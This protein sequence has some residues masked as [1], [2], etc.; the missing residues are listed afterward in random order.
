MLKLISWIK[1]NQRLRLPALILI[2]SA[3]IHLINLGYPDSVVFDEVYFGK[4]ATSYCCSGKNF[5]TFHPPHGILLIAGAAKLF[6]YKGTVAFN[7]I[8]QT[9]GAESPVGLRLVPALSGTVLPLIL[10]VLLRQLGAS[11]AASLMGA[12]LVMFDNA[13]ILQSRVIALDALLL[14]AIFSSLACFIAATRASTKAHRWVLASGCLAGLA[15]GIKFT[16]LVAVGLPGVM[17]LMIVLRGFSQKKLTDW[18]VKWGTFFVGFITIYLAGWYLHFALLTQPG[19]G[20]AWMVASGN[21]FADTIHLHQKMLS[22]NIGL[23]ATHQDGSPWWTWPIMRT[24]VY[25]WGQGDSALYLIGNPVIWWGIAVLFVAVLIDIIDIGLTRITQ[26]RIDTANKQP[27]NYLWL[28]IFGYAIALFPLIWVPRVLFMYHYLTALLFSIMAAVLWLDY[29]GWT[30]TG[31]IL[32]QRKSY[33]AVAALIIIGFISLFPLTY[34]TQ[35][36]FQTVQFWFKWFPGW[37]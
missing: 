10:F 21:F 16:G 29:A 14:L 24:P 35:A 9:Y 32:R 20:D 5:F 17:T 33:Y 22:V 26:K 4:Y 31:G 28:P 13:I 3:G 34:G 36:G 19:T 37:R 30:N 25:Y 11:N 23:T 15:T 27:C 12:L 8:G 7:K 1:N 6:G 2:L 18:T